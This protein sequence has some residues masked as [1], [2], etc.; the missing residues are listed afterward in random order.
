M[1]SASAS[2]SQSSRSSG[3]TPAP[4]ISK[5]MNTGTMLQKPS[6]HASS[7]TDLSLL[8]G[9]MSN[10]HRGGKKFHD[11]LS[12]MRWI[13]NFTG[14][15]CDPTSVLLQRAD[16]EELLLQPSLPFSVISEL[17]KIFG[18]PDFREQGHT[19]R[20]LQIV[21]E[22]P[23]IRNPKNLKA[24]IIKLSGAPSPATYAYQENL[25]NVLDVIADIMER[26]PQFTEI[27][28]LDLLQ[29][30]SAKIAASYPKH[31]FDSS[32]R[33][34]RRGK[35]L[36]GTAS[37]QPSF[38]PSATAA[39]LAFSS[40]RSSPAHSDILHT[41]SQ[42]LKA[43]EVMKS[44]DSDA[45]DSSNDSSDE[46]LTDEE[47]EDDDDDEPLPS[48]FRRLPLFPTPSEIMADP[49][50]L[51]KRL[52]RNIT[53]GKYESLTHYLD[54]HFRLLRE[55]ALSSIRDGI[56]SWR[57][58]VASAPSLKPKPSEVSFYHSVR[59][60]GICPTFSGIV[61][62]ISFQLSDPSMGKRKAVDTV[63]VDWRRSQRLLYGSL[64]CL[65]P[66]GFKTLIWATV[67]NRDVSLLS[68]SQEVD[69]K[70]ADEAHTLLDPS[71]SYVMVEST[72]TYYEAYRHVLSALKTANIHT[73]PFLE[74]LVHSKTSIDSATY[75]KAGSS[76]YSL[77]NVFEGDSA[78]EFDI[79]APWPSL[80]TS[81]DDSQLDAVKNALTKEI[82]VIQGPPGTG[83]TFVGLKVM[84]ALLDNR[85]ARGLGANGPILVVCF[86]NHALDQF[87]EGIMQF[88][89]NVVR[90]GSRSKSELLKERNLK[91]LLMEMNM[92][93]NEHTKTR[94]QMLSS[95]KDLQETIEE[96]YL[97][98]AKT[99]LSSSDLFAAISDED[100]DEDDDALISSL[101]GKSLGLDSTSEAVIIENW[102]GCSPS[103]LLKAFQSSSTSTPAQ[104]HQAEQFEA[105]FPSL[106]TAASLGAPVTP[107]THSI[108]DEIIDE[109]DEEKEDEME[110]RR[111]DLYDVPGF[112][113]KMMRLSP[114]TSIKGVADDENT[115]PLHILECSN[116]WKLPKTDR[117]RLYLYWL[118]RFRNR[119][120]T[121]DLV[122]MCEKY[123]H[124][125]LQKQVV[126]QDA[127]IQLLMSSAVIGLT[128]TGVAKFQKLIR[129]VGP[130][131]VVVEEAA[132]VLEAHIVTAL[133]PSTKQL[134]LIGD[135]EQLRPSTAVHRLAIKYKL[136]V[137]LFE[138]LINNGFPVHSLSRQ[139]RMRP[140]ISRLLMSIYPHLSNHP[141]VLSPPNIKGVGSNVYFID[142][143]HLE[144]ADSEHGVSKHNHHEATFLGRF[145]AH[146]LYQGYH[147]RQ[148][149]ILTAY[150]GQVK[151]IRQELRARNI[152]GVYVTSV[153]NYQGQENDIICLSLV[154][155]NPQGTIGFL[156]TSNRICVALSRARIGL[157]IMGNAS[158]LD[159]SNNPVWRFILAQ[160]RTNH[161]IGTQ[162]TL[163]CQN[164]PEK[165]AKVS[166]AV[167]FDCH[168]ADG[169][170]ELPCS[171][172]L[173]C[174]HPCSRFC[175][176]FSHD[177]VLC[178]RPC[179]HF[180]PECGHRCLKRCHQECLSCEIPVVRTL[181]CGHECSMLC[182]DDP[183]PCNHPITVVLPCSHSVTTLCMHINPA[184]STQKAPRLIECPQCTN[185]AVHT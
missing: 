132:E 109:I 14:P 61:Y 95:M 120:V 172:T 85:G 44:D 71:L 145:A 160:L 122:E 9:S 25:S 116:V 178:M 144:G 141:D 17:M 81:M 106:A 105:E 56:K 94:K 184:P 169:G 88:E 73:F 104:R 57:T 127:Q 59:L 39:S 45:S 58:E 153:D 40:G 89:A 97:D 83:K 137:S 163:C 37:S 13:Q 113:L 138:R 27:L 99:S 107:S 103:E 143:I 78:A 8:G 75:L 12:M 68:M 165:M 15:G 181:H 161:A 183:P 119:V 126:D 31:I 146:L 20:V 22:S 34:I 142:H 67:A 155:S 111:E 157:Y 140:E 52:S 51:A 180:F 123:E 7:Q 35:E 2:S 63:L 135:H 154:R 48:D 102:L 26:Y 66:D 108:E 60:T 152:L 29:I 164:H 53:H 149:T 36:L 74:Y 5:R 86:T 6:N 159:S 133:T 82:S 3:S 101:F 139:R 182:S 150:S 151:L 70:F 129:A 128:T 166:T 91:S 4:R 42:Q 131:I 77:K 110:E 18:H 114:E 92:H 170:C 148:I 121:P 174:G 47:D 65:S 62:R 134:I 80:P 50:D 136:D 69:I 179:E 117:H 177:Q 162:L 33:I 32:Q 175:H 28:G 11:K 156:N 98:L 112:S 168:S 118:S 72:S 100:N 46:D 54:T 55:D 10:L 19:D 96:R 130:S 171:A 147:E 158:Q 79:L 38:S 64:L 76:L 16:L 24:Y 30:S 124:L 185:N 125:C 43:L 1:S 167:D 176:P 87:L 93:T 84:R 173:P 41:L 115:L 90:I 23:L 49:D 21:A